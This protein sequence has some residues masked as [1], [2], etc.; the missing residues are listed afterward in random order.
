[1]RWLRRTEKRDTDYSDAVVQQLIANARA[2]KTVVPTATAAWETG[3][4]IVSRAFASAEVDAPERIRP[5]LSSSFLAMLSRALMRTG[6]FLA[7]IDVRDGR[8][9]LT[10]AASWTV[11]GGYEETT[12][13]YELALAGPS[14]QTV[15]RFIPSEGVLHIRHSVDPA[16]P[17]K[18][19]SP[20]QAAALAGALSAE[21]TAALADEATTPRGHLLPLPV[22]GDDDTVVALRRDIGGAKGDVLLVEAQS[23]MA[24]AG[25]SEGWLPRRFGPAPPDAMVQLQEI[26]TREI[27]S[28][29]GVPPVLFGA[30]VQGN[31]A[32]EAWR[33]LLFGTIAPLG[34]MVAA[35][36]SAKLEAE[37]VLDWTELRASDIQGRARSFQAM[38]TGGM[39]VE[40]AAI[41]AGLTT[42]ETD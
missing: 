20:I 36:M 7:A 26:A 19:Y 33:L 23:R 30:S 37:I 21:T 27:L 9:V 41:L 11:T 12:W 13:L 42:M 3:A 38:V 32:R 5:A 22:P 35:E 34:K 39:D 24:T 15:R 2:T 17:W 8:V 18:G 40:R 31:S 16:R 29:M 6:E 4:G 28:A 10:P 14:D 25:V 1:M